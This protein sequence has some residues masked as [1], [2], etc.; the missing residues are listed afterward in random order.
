VQNLD[1]WLAYRQALRDLP[2]VTS[3]PFNPTWP[4]APSA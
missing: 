2:A 3:D 4:E 1:Q